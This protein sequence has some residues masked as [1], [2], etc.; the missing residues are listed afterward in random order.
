MQSFILSSLM[1]IVTH[2]C[3]IGCINMFRFL[4]FQRKLAIEPYSFFSGLKAQCDFLHFDKSQTIHQWNI[5]QT[6]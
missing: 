5:F 2:M 1:R 4:N 6:F 3:I